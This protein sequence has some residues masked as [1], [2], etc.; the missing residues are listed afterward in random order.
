MRF[1]RFADNMKVNSPLDDFSLYC[2][3]NAVYEGL[4]FQE[5]TLR[6]AA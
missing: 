3:F 1:C 6:Y 2:C 4:E 5:A